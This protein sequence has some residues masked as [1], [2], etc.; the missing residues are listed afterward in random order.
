MPG[1]EIFPTDDAAAT[2]VAWLLAEEERD[3]SGFEIVA[4]IAGE[5][6]KIEIVERVAAVKLVGRGG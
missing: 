1:W 2:K 5:A 4:I 6:L 3:P